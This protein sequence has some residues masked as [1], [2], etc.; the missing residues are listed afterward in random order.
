VSLCFYSWFAGLLDGEGY[1]QIVRIK[2]KDKSDKYLYLPM[3]GIGMRKD[4]API[5]QM[6]KNTTGLGGLCF[7]KRT[8][9]SLHMPKCVWQVSGVKQCRRL[10]EILEGYPLQSKKRRDYKVWRSYV[11][12]KA[13]LRNKMP[14][15]LCEYYFHRIKEARE[16]NPIVASSY[17]MD[18]RSNLPIQRGS[19]L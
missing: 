4:D 3:A 2:S 6:I 18:I 13:E 14:V 9:S 15:S 1:F 17:E 8:Q 5:L 12:Q 10:V 16:F 11:L 7:A 19:V